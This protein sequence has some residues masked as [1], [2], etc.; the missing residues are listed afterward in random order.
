MA[1]ND[2]Q[3]L[4]KLM[5]RMVKALEGSSGVSNSYQSRLGRG[6]DSNGKSITER[7][8]SWAGR[9]ADMEKA[10]SKFEKN[11]KSSGELW[12]ETLR[13]A[14]GATRI[15]GKSARALSAA[16]D[17]LNDN[18]TKATRKVTDAMVDM[19]K[20]FGVSSKAMKDANEHAIKMAKMLGELNDLQ[21]KRKAIEE[22]QGKI[23]AL[24]L[25]KQGLHKKKDKDQIK[26]ID[27]SI[28]ALKSLQT[29]QNKVNSDIN[30]LS[31]EII[32]FRNSV[33][34]ASPAIKELTDSFLVL[35]NTATGVE[36]SFSNVSKASEELFD[37]IE[38]QTNGTRTAAVE[39][40][41]L[42]D[43]I[44]ETR[45]GLV[46]ALSGLA[47][48]L[49]SAG[50]GFIKEFR[51][52]LRYNVK[53]HH[54][55]A[56]LSMGMSAPQLYETLGENADTFRR[57]T[58]SADNAA[59]VKNGSLKQLQTTTTSLYGLSGKEAAD[60]ISK[61]MQA[62]QQSGFSTANTGNMQK[63][64]RELSLFADQIQM[65]KESLISLKSDLSEMGAL[66]L[67]S[68]KYASQGQERAQKALNEEIAARIANSKSLGKSTEEFKRQVQAQRANQF[69]T[70]ESMI[71]KDIGAE[72]EIDAFNNMGGTTSAR[73]TKLLRAEAKGVQLQ[74]QDA[75]DL[76]NYKERQLQLMSRKTVAAAN[77]G[78]ATGNYDKAYELGVT[79]T[80]L[81]N[82]AS[83]M[84]NTDMLSE[85]QKREGIRTASGDVI[86]VTNGAYAAN[87]KARGGRA[88]DPNSTNGVLPESQMLS[89][90]MTWW[91]GAMANP[92]AS[93]A[94][95]TKKILL[96]LVAYFGK[97][98]VM[99]AWDKLK[100][101]KVPPGGPK[102]ATNMLGKLGT[103]GKVLGKIAAPIA[104]IAA[105]AD[106]A[107]NGFG[108]KNTGDFLA[109]GAMLAG[110]SVGAAAGA[111]WGAGRMVDEF[112][113]DKFDATKK[114][115]ENVAG[116]M[117]WVA[118]VFGLGV[119]SLS[120]IEAK[121]KKADE[122]NVKLQAMIA[123]NKWKN[124]DSPQ[125]TLARLQ[126]AEA[127]DNGDRPRD[128]S[129][130]VELIGPQGQAIQDLAAHSKTT[131]NN[132]K[133][134]ADEARKTNEFYMSERDL[135]ASIAQKEGMASQ[136][137]T[138]F[139]NMEVN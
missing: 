14:S 46:D 28:A 12:R 39:M 93:I 34:D 80:I 76:E 104:M 33:S 8:S 35:D 129:I 85:A 68:Q 23:D 32:D 74:G 109:G 30:D 138:R 95:D 7:A 128:N 91:D 65:T 40:E 1:A 13:D 70:I 78:F 31:K 101:P 134:Q 52:Q 71:K 18:Q 125:A 84:A 130:K 29:E 69:G 27:D 16:A 4:T 50:V 113:L 41:K 49:G 17:A 63:E 139:A 131:A 43:A 99:G 126:A 37:H 66:A 83:D 62:Q 56:A 102:A 54:N 38:A 133:K 137:A 72:L 117:N 36:I 48:S 24:K 122:D 105:G 22:S 79:R 120:S 119:E 77:E 44:Q 103:A 121:N 127:A 47:K 5:E 25:E 82:F 67:M 59:V 75:I 115:K 11:V 88:D 107:E 21:N 89:S 2:L 94:G 106:I 123:M 6:G 118:N 20:E 98:L 3:Q 73:E 114:G 100:G 92:M 108:I 57:T 64:L 96:L 45:K 97:K 111:G 124:S 135:K 9:S 53:D 42:E 19:A 60:L 86:G 26:A 110:G 55:M 10:I 87:N 132:T 51:S 61:V 58:N 112:V 15:F 81:G 90:L 116:G 136:T